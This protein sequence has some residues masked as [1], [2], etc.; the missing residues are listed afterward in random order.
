MPFQG[1]MRAIVSGRLRVLE[2]ISVQR[3]AL[4][5]FSQPAEASALHG[6]RVCFNPGVNRTFSRA[7]RMTLPRNPIEKLKSFFLVT[8]DSG[9]I[10]KHNIGAFAR[11]QNLKPCLMWAHMRAC[12]GVQNYA[13]AMLSCVSAESR[14]HGVCG[15]KTEPPRI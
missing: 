8:R 1:R 6:N 10:F 15:V 14:R 5:R 12:S 9:V 2:S 4:N 7:N 3:S 13:A 11:T